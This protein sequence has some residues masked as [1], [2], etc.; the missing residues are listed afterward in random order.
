MCTTACKV[1]INALHSAWTLPTSLGRST[2]ADA[3]LG[4]A[5]GLIPVGH[6][7]ANHPP[8]IGYRCPA[9]KP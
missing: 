5:P 1:A 7:V 8:V 3:F 9:R 6:R 2:G 4:L